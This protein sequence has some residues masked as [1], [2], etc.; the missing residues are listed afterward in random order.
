MTSF[1]VRKIK[2]ERTVG[3]TLKSKRQ[4]L[5]L[6]LQE[7][8]KDTKISFNYLLALESGSYEKMPG[9]VYAKNFLRVYAQA[10]ELPVKK[11]EHLFLEETN[12]RK[13]VK[14]ANV[15]HYKPVM[16]ASRWHFLAT[17]KLVRNSIITLA[18]LAVVVYVGFRVQAIISPPTLNIISPA[19]DL[20][21]NSQVTTLM[22]QTDPEVTIAIN[23]KTIVTN[24]DGSFAE[25]LDLHNGTNII[26]ITAHK[27]HGKEQT[28]YRR[29]VVSENN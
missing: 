18:F 23:G 22:G 9:L 20:V 21:I 29:I 25:E 19:E 27:K 8:S 11:L 12:A 14:I 6:D 16:K 10:L 13:Q 24:A 7:V 3:E 15:K 1:L 26:K 4:E 2:S 28:I 5:G 17:P